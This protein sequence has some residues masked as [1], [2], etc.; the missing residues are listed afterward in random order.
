MRSN[1]LT[2][3]P[4]PSTTDG[5]PLWLV[6]DTG[7]LDGKPVNPKA[8]ALYQAICRPGTIR[9]IHGDAVIVN[10]GKIQ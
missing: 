10:N 3:R 2:I 9:P 1:K 4:S 8:T 7:M 5:K 6:D